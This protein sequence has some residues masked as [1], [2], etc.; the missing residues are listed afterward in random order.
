MHE[1]HKRKLANIVFLYF[2]LVFV[3]FAVIL[4]V[5]ESSQCCQL[6]CVSAVVV[7]KMIFPLKRVFYV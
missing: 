7:C 3:L 5:S 2:C 4:I 1:H 6:N